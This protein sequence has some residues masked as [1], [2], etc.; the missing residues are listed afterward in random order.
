ML[1][2][3]DNY[4]V[5]LTT[6]VNLGVAQ[7]PIDRNTLDSLVWHASCAGWCGPAT[8]VTRISGERGEENKKSLDVTDNAAHSPTLPREPQ[9]LCGNGD[10]QTSKCT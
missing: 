5:I 2:H 7:K 8:C 3:E 4:S 10:P 6:H 1:L 9:A